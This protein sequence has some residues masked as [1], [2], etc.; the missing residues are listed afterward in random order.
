[1]LKITKT[2]YMT[3]GKLWVLILMPSRPI[4]LKDGLKKFS[5]LSIN[6]DTLLN[7]EFVWA[8]LP[9]STLASISKTTELPSSSISTTLG[10]TCPSTDPICSDL[11]KLRVTPLSWKSTFKTKPPP[12]LVL[13]FWREMPLKTKTLS[14]DWWIIFTLNRIIDWLY[15][16]FLIK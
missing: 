4:S 5:S 9:P 10:S 13:K 16:I 2:L 1:M 15:V 14:I 8:T 11:P 7:K 6:W 3:L 12:L